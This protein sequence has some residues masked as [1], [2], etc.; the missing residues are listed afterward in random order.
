MYSSEETSS[1]VSKKLW[2]RS[3]VCFILGL[4]FLIAAVTCRFVFVFVYEHT[5]E[6]QWPEY[7]SSQA[8]IFTKRPTN[9]FEAIELN[10]K[11]SDEP[12]VPTLGEV[13]LYNGER[14][15]NSSVT[16]YFTPEVSDVPG[17]LSG[18]EVDYYGYIEDNL[19]G[20][21]FSEK[22]TSN[23]GTYHSVAIALRNSAIEDLCS[24]SSTT[25]K[26]EKAEEKYVTISPGM[27]NEQI[28]MTDSSPSLI[29]TW[30]K[31]SC[32]P[33]MGYHW[34][35]DIHGGK[36]L[37]YEAKNTAPLVPMYDSNGTFV[38]IFFLATAKKQHW[39]DTCTFTSEECIN[40]LNFWDGG[41]GLTQANA[42]KFYM[43]SNLCGKCDFTGSGSTPGI[44][45]TM[46]WF[47]T[48][49]PTSIECVGSNMGPA[50]YC[51]SGSYPKDF[52]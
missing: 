12:C 36:N 4:V 15:L 2:F 49:D 44:Y 18:I 45:T 10:W 19:I 35:R 8:G 47:F 17:S 6:P 13:W 24:A 7:L 26:I 5:S 46:H 43:C 9:T 32:I 38:A 25:I 33:T 27:A 50:P 1:T 30:K 11:K 3:N 20:L 40:T 48:K 22:M 34:M 52:V 41:P 42:G 28:P 29:D 37:T 39:A 16:L 14:G 21:Y 23:D 31:G 51:P